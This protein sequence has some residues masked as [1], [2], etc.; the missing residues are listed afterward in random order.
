MQDNSDLGKQSRVDDHAIKHDS[1]GFGVHDE[2]TSLCVSYWVY[3]I[4]LSQTL[5]GKDS[6]FRWLPTDWDLKPRHLLQAR[7]NGGP[8]WAVPTLL[9]SYAAQGGHGL[10][11][12]QQWCPP[13]YRQAP[14]QTLVTLRG[15]PNAPMLP[16]K[17]L[18]TKSE[19]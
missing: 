12:N 13:A 3:Y 5:G 14:P 9:G 11:E 18:Q 8:T 2:E 4:K 10:W 6:P 7:S 19:S 15:W 16:F 17:A 1:C